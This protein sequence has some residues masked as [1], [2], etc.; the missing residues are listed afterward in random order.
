MV[1]EKNILIHINETVYNFLLTLYDSKSSILEIKA[2]VHDLKNN[3][4]I[5][6]KDNIYGK[7]IKF[8]DDE[9]INNLIQ[10]L[11]QFHQTIT[12]KIDN[13]CNHEW[14]DDLID[15]NCEKS[16]SFTYCKICEI[17]QKN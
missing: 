8:F 4:F 3:Y 9:A 17:S 5:E 1:D 15:L 10:D 14:V 11:Q 13:C 6:D 12:N 2:D 7:F 16:M